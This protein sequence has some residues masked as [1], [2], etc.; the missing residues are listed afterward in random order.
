MAVREKPV[1]RITAT[2]VRPN[3]VKAKL[4]TTIYVFTAFVDVCKND[5]MKHMD[6]NSL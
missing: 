2:D 6:F 1:T 3:S 4:S 5:L